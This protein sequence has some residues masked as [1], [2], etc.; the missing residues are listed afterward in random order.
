M[1]FLVFDTETTGVDPNVDQIIELCIKESGKEPRTRRIYPSMAKMTKGAQ[2]VH[3]ISMEDLAECPT[4]ALLATA[5]RKIFEEADVLIGYNVQFDIDMVCAE[6]DRLGQTLDL[7]D[8]IIVDPLKL[9]RNKERR[10]LE[11]A[12]QR[13]VGK[14]LSGAHAAENDV[15]AT[16]EVLHAMLKEWNLGHTPWAEIALECEPERANY[17]GATHHFIYHEEGHVIFNFGKHKG[18]AVSQE[19]GYLKWMQGSGFPPSV[20]KVIEGINAG[21]ISLE[22]KGE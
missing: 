22:G 12:H 4:F 11:A 8:K 20:L 3:G 5:L 15:L 16:E 7:S 2:D 17:V 1:K 13:F 18:K 21:T 19:M 14:E 6:F 10:T 9:W